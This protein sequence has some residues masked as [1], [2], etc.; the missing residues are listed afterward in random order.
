MGRLHKLIGVFFAFSPKSQH[1]YALIFLVQLAMSKELTQF[2]FSSTKIRA[3]T[4]FIPTVRQKAFFS[5]S[6]YFEILDMCLDDL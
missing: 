5:Y 1:E 3:L 2:Q 6:L 4:A